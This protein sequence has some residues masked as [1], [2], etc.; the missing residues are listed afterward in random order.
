VA[1][2]EALDDEASGERTLIEAGGRAQRELDRRARLHPVCPSGRFRVDQQPHDGVA[3]A[4]AQQGCQQPRGIAVAA[5]AG[6]VLG[7]GQD[8]GAAGRT[9]AHRVPDGI[10]RAQQVEHEL[11]FG[12]VHGMAQL[13]DRGPGLHRTRTVAD[14]RHP[15]LVEVGHREPG[16]EGQRDAGSRFDRGQQS[17]QPR[18]RFDERALRRDAR[19]EVQLPQ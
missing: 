19:Q 14:H 16:R 12:F 17:E 18:P 4:M 8:D 6:I 1:I 10:V 15:A 7:V 9:D 3:G 11:R 13:V 5:G 2:A